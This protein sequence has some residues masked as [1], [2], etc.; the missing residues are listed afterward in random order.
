VCA[1]KLEP[2]KGRSRALQLPLD[3]LVDGAIRSQSESFSGR[4]SIKAGTSNSTLPTQ[5]LVGGER[6][7]AVEDEVEGVV[8][9]ATGETIAAVPRGT[10]ADVD[11]AVEAATG[12]V[13]E[14]LETTPQERA[15]ALLRLADALTEHAEE[16]ARVES[17]N[18]GKPVGM[19]EAPDVSTAGRPGSTC[20]ATPP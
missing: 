19:Q 17:L 12:A 11:R 3:Q 10:E 8:N 16:L 2:W 20:A 5:T 15:E 14:W 7:D 4:A 1:G 9:P 13:P 6:L 18:V